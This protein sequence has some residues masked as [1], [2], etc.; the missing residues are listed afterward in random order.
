MYAMLFL[1]VVALA[2]IAIPAF[3]IQPF[4]SQ[5]ATDLQLAFSNAGLPPHRQ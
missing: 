1:L 2:L 4:R 3:I 5:S